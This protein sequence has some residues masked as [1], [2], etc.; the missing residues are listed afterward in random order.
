MKHGQRN[1]LKLLGS[2]ATIQA[3]AETTDHIHIR[4]CFRPTLQIIF[5]Q[6]VRISAIK[7][8][9]SNIFFRSQKHNSLAR[10]FKLNK[11]S[12]LTEIQDI[13]LFFAQFHKTQGHA[14]ANLAVISRA[15]DNINLYLFSVIFLERDDGRSVRSVFRVV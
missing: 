8:G 3:G 15:A 7:S 4:R 13:P 14:M 5:N 2:F 9:A 6:S 11:G 12:Y 10:L 1:P